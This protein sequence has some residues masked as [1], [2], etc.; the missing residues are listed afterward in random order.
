[1][2]TCAE[3]AKRIDS[4]ESLL[5]GNI[6]D[7]VKDLATKMLKKFE[8]QGVGEHVKLAETVGFV[9]DQYDSLLAKNAELVAVNKELVA[10]NAV[11]EKKVTDMEQYSRLNNIEIKGIPTTKGEDC[12]AILQCVAAAIDCPISTADIDTVHRVSTKSKEKNLIAR[13]CS[14]DKKNEF[15]RKAR[16][17]RLRTNQLGFAGD[18]DKPVFVNDHLTVENKRLFAKALNLKKEKQ[19]Q[20]LWTDNCQ[21]LARMN[22]DCKVSRIVTEADLRIFN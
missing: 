7:L 9:S 21:I 8:E 11:L 14:R 17:A 5:K 12:K 20:F 10:R 2:P 16:K 18:N 1:M 13:F 4:L 3:L 22:E 6:D 15:V 19:W